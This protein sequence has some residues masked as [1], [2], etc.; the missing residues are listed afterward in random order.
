MPSLF[1][2]DM[3]ITSYFIK[4]IEHELGR[5]IQSF[6]QVTLEKVDTCS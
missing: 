4:M 6:L 1:V 2:I 3:L 5:L